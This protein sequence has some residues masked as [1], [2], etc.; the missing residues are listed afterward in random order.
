MEEAKEA[1]I[2]KEAK[3]FASFVIFASFASSAHKMLQ[4]TRVNLTIRKMY[5][6]FSVSIGRETVVIVSLL[7]G[8]LSS[9][10]PIRKHRAY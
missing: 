10:L 8:Q 2:T 1:K 9:A 3:K 5:P 6:D 4:S 7:L